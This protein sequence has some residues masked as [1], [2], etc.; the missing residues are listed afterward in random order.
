MLMV[1][2]GRDPEDSTC[3]M[4]KS[5]TLRNDQERRPSQSTPIAIRTAWLIVGRHPKNL[6]NE[7]SHTQLSLSSCSLALLR[8]GVL[9][10]SVNHS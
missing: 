3:A 10:P 8:S 6:H 1:R 9:K 5:I 4:P 7:G 2:H